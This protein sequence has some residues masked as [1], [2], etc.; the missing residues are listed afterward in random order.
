MK[1]ILFFA[2]GLCAVSGYA[3]EGKVGINTMVPQ[4]TLDV[5]SKTGVDEKTNSFQLQNANGKMLVKVLD[6]GNVGIGV[7]KPTE[8][9]EIANNVKVNSLSGERNRLVFADEKGV[10][11]SQLL[12]IVGD[13]TCNDE[14]VGKIYLSP[15]GSFLCEKR[16]DYYAGY[17]W[18][19][20]GR[21]YIKNAQNQWIEAPIP[22]GGVASVSSLI[23]K[24]PTI[25]SFMWVNYE[26]FDGGEII[27]NNM[28]LMKELR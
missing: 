27:I 14:N 17:R 10:L 11:K 2:L 18:S 15:D 24:Y 6:N 26:L 7:D 25:R 12:H 5:K 1:K 13:V 8:N 3:Q 9:I 21:Y 22:S 16:V 23:L 19:Y 28:W 4:A 20:R